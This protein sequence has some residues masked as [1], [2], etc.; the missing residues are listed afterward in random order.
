MALLGDVLIS[1]GFGFDVQGR[2]R[3]PTMVRKTVEGINEE[4]TGRYARVVKQ[5]SVCFDMSDAYLFNT[6]VKR[7]VLFIYKKLRKILILI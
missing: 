3:K 6:A 2:Q 1:N 5:V 4:M 7:D